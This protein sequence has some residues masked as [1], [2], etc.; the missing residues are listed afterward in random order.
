MA[1]IRI[2]V[3]FEDE[4]KWFQYGNLLFN[5]L[6]CAEE[7]IGDSNI[8]EFTLIREDEPEKTAFI[9]W[10]GTH[11]ACPCFV[12]VGFLQGR[13]AVSS[14]CAE[15]FREGDLISLKIPGE[16]FD[17]DALIRFRW[18]LSG[19]CRNLEVGKSY[20]PNEFFEVIS[21]GIS[22]KREEARKDKLRFE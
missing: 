2:S 5:R 1:E 20:S 6:P 8:G 9:M 14:L 21:E 17:F 13:Y 3:V 12:G 18:A 10:H 16:N 4:E 11:C 15:D 19:S 22:A 7:F